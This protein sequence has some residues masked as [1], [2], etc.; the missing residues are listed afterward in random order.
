MCNICPFLSQLYN[1]NRNKG[2]NYL[3]YLRLS[4]IQLKE[5]SGGQSRF[6]LHYITKGN[7]WLEVQWLRLLDVNNYCK[8]SGEKPTTG[9]S[10]P[11]VLQIFVDSCKNLPSN[12]VGLSLIHI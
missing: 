11:A 12:K 9:A 5:T 4:L 7:L 6:P 1:Y 10:L 8:N 2:D 3:G